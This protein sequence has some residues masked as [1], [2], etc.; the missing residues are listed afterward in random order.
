MDISF[1]D[2]YLPEGC[3]ESCEGLSV[4]HNEEAAEVVL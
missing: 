2:S 3:I 1:H 4:E